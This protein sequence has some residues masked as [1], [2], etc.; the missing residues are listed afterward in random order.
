MQR[1]CLT[2][3]A[4][5]FLYSFLGTGMNRYINICKYTELKTFRNWQQNKVSSIDNLMVQAGKKNKKNYEK[6]SHDRFAIDKASQM[7]IQEYNKKKICLISLSDRCKF[8]FTGSQTIKVHAVLAC[9]CLLYYTKIS[10]N[11][12]SMHVLN[13]FW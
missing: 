6:N 5:V 3:F 12:I 13:N 9:Y 1:I 2:R 7:F 4:Y 10:L 11:C 8:F